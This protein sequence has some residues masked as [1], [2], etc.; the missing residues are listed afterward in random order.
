MRKPIITLAAGFLL[1][2]SASAVPARRVPLLVTQPDGNTVTVVLNG[3]E[4]L[5]YYTTTDGVPV[6]QNAAGAYCYATLEGE[7]LVP[8]TLMAHDASL[9]SAEEQQFV[10]T[11]PQVASRLVAIGLRR[12]EQRNASRRAPQRVGK[13]GVTTGQHKGLV[14]LVNFQ[15]KKM[16][17]ANTREQFD[18]MMN[19]VGYSDNGNAGSVHDYFLAQSYGKFDLTFDV[20]GPVTVSKNLADYGGNYGPMGDDVDPFG[21]VYEACQLAAPQV[22]F[23]KYDWDG[24]GEVDQV[25]LICAGNSEAAGGSS[26]SIW[27]HESKLS[28]SDYG[29]LTYNGVDIDTY[30]CSTELYGTSTTQMD[31]I[32]VSC[33]EFSHCMGLP[34]FY[35]KNYNGGFGMGSWSVMSGG[36]YNGGGYVPVG[37]NAYERWFS[38]W[39]EPTELTDARTVTGLRSL[40]AHPEAYLIR[41]EANPNEFYMLE[42]RQNDGWFAKDPSHGLLV[43]HV[44]YVPSLWEDN[45]VN[46]NLKT[47]HCTILPA[48]NSLTTKD[49][50]GDLYPNGGLNPLLTNI[51]LPAATLYAQQPDGTNNMG[52]PVT[53][54]TEA[55]GLISFNFRG[56]DLIDAPVATLAN[57]AASGTLKAQWTAVEGADAYDVELRAIGTSAADKALLAAEDFGS[58]GMEITDDPDTDLSHRLDENGTSVGWSG[59]RLYLG[60]LGLQ[61]GNESY[62]GEIVSPSFST[63]QSGGVTVQFAESPDNFA[64]TL[65]V[66]LRDERNNV[67][68]SKAV[69]LTDEEHT[70]QFAGVTEPFRVAFNT[71][72]TFAYLSGVCTIHDGLFTADEVEA[73]YVGADVTPKIA[74]GI[75]GTS[76]TFDGL[77][78]GQTYS[79]HV[80][81]HRGVISSAWSTPVLCT[82]GTGSGISNATAE[83]AWTTSTPVTV[84]T[85]SGQLLRHASFGHWAAG[86]SAG[87]YV[88]KSGNASRV[89]LAR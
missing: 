36:S 66:T 50:A 10:A 79:L 87:A 73:A 57:A 37:Y 83:S 33:H 86:L 31:G 4:S 8:T 40:D 78:A 89:L 26:E 14:I 20:V 44:D 53:D 48:D 3:D 38:G 63:P 51:S 6:A 43:T 11:N 61:V 70:L 81:A 64:Q 22:D 46:T 75:S 7:R 27:P 30:G 69:D 71:P 56:G 68:Q 72:S 2:L 80:R 5:H 28:K 13:P 74:K 12:M 29:K 19:E 59:V 45:N 23:S 54:I 77:T 18:R 41:S 60:D 84:Y 58:M 34:D 67:M 24:D 65:L 42:N 76:H 39:L 52:K 55:N 35:D 62:M 85:L 9:R 82:V 32:G 88:V 16:N 47:P 25:F 21:M 49:E 1:A 15:D 17:A